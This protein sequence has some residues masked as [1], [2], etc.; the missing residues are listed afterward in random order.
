MSQVKR[1]NT[2]AILKDVEKCM[3]RPLI[4]EHTCAGIPVKDPLYATGFF[5]ASDLQGVMSYK[6]TEEP[7]QVGQS[8]LYA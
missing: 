1:N 4:S 5:V 7:T 2:S 6:D 8:S 3:A